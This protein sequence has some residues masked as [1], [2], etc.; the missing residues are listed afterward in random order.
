MAISSSAII[1]LDTGVSSHF[2]QSVEWQFDTALVY[3]EGK[4][5]IV[6]DIELIGLPGYAPLGDQSTA[7]L[8]FTRDGRAWTTERARNIAR[9]GARSPNPRWLPNWPM[10]H[11]LGMRFRGVGMSVSGFA[12]LQIQAEALAV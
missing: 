5:G 9:R 8:S 2:G 10:R 4:G 6:H 1:R 11:W 7:F 12:D 3:N